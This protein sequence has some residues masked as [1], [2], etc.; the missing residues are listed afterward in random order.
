VHRRARE[1][2]APL[3]RAG[4]AVCAICGERIVGEFHLGHS[5]DRSSYI[6]ATHP[7]CNVREAGLKTARLWRGRST[8]TSREW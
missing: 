7:R 8:V 2:L 3:V 1:Q 6:G 5:D 4:L